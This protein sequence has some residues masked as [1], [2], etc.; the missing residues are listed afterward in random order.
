MVRDG[1][2]IVLGHQREHVVRDA[3][4]D[5]AGDSQGEIG[6]HET[7]GGVRLRLWGLHVGGDNRECSVPVFK[8]LMRQTTIAPGQFSPSE[9]CREDRSQL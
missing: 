8:G 9:G 7:T 1:I 5:L 3:V 4:S 2:L 6:L